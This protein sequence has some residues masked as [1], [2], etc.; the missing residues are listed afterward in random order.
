MWV[1][2]KNVQTKDGCGSYMKEYKVG[3]APEQDM[4]TTQEVFVR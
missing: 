3:L 2:F 4:T 1:R